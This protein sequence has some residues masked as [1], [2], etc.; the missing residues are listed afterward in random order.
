VKPAPSHSPTITEQL[1][2]ADNNLAQAL[3]GEQG[4]NLRL[5]GRLLGVK[6]ASRGHQVQLTRL[7][8][9]QT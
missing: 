5:I 2:L 8:A 4:Q 3:F 6:L 1:T 7:A 9:A